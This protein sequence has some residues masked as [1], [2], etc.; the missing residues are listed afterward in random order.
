MEQ[1]ELPPNE[2]PEVLSPMALQ[3]V[4]KAHINNHK[5]CRAPH[6]SVKRFADEQRTI[7]PRLGAKAPYRGLASSTMLKAETSC[8]RPLTTC[9]TKYSDSRLPKHIAWEVIAEYL[10]FAFFPRG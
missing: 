2:G 3:L 1:C 5:P 8:C 9:I 7:E 4:R 6:I 10:S